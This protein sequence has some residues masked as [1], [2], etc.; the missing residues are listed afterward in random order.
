MEIKSFIELKN[1]SLFWLTQLMRNQH[2]KDYLHICSLWSVDLIQLSLKQGELPLHFSIPF[3]SCKTVRWQNVVKRTY[4]CAISFAN[5][6]CT[7]NASIWNIDTCLTKQTLNCFQDFSGEFILL[8]LHVFNSQGEASTILLILF[9]ILFMV[10]SIFPSFFLK[11]QV[12]LFQ[13]CHVLLKH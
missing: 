9:G 13:V 1:D 5:T 12:F 7:I 11:I 6:M 8:F 2:W 3:Y 10:V 4:R